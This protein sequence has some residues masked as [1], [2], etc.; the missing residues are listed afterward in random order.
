MSSSVPYLGSKISIISKSEIRYEGILYTVDPKESTI[1]LAKVRSFGTER[2]PTDHPVAPRDEIHE[3]I[4]FRASDIK[5]LHVCE[6]PKSHHGLSHD[7]AIVQSG[8]VTNYSSISQ[9]YNAFYGLQNFPAFQNFPSQ[10]NSYSCIPSVLTA[11]SGLKNLAGQ[12]S[13]RKSPTID[14]SVQVSVGNE[15]GNLSR[16]DREPLKQRNGD[17]MQM[18]RQPRRRQSF[19]RQPNIRRNVQRRGQ[20]RTS[21]LERFENEYDFEQANAEFQELENKLSK[22]TIDD[23]TENS[24]ATEDLSFTYDKEKSFFDD[25][26][27]EATQRS[28]GLPRFDWRYERKLNVETFGVSANNA[29]LR[30][31][32]SRGAMRRGYRGRAAYNRTNEPPKTVTFDET[33]AVKE[34]E[35]V[36][37]DDEK[38]A[39]LPVIEV[40]MDKEKNDWP[41]PTAKTESVWN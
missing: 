12:S 14:A 28:K 40:V 22:N 16:L 11:H 32:R 15:N 35:T 3:Y 29:W 25:I 2:R 4:I 23:N 20:G 39:Q 18:N 19:N 37:V 36:T 10:M 30:R 1:A 34:V 31:R 5:D 9:P 33:P 24:P 26:S 41:D 27:C 6:P 7:P 38:P 13:Q 17:Q 8:P 21:T